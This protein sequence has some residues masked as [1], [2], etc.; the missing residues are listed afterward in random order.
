MFQTADNKKGLSVFRMFRQRKKVLI[1]SEHSDSGRRSLYSGN[2]PDSGKGACIWSAFGFS[3]LAWCPVGVNAEN[4][5]S[6]QI[7][8]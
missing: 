4:S 3:G 5:K 1:P 7:V 8:A 6:G 2:G